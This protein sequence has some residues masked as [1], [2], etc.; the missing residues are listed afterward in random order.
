MFHSTTLT[1]QT[2]W[3]EFWMVIKNT[4]TKNEFTKNI[5]LFKQH[6]H[7]KLNTTEFDTEVYEINNSLIDTKEK[8]Q[9]QVPSV[10]NSFVQFSVSWPW[11]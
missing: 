8:Q 5:I 1:T 7:E 6:C 10:M 4:F 2:G 9:L 11:R 3:K